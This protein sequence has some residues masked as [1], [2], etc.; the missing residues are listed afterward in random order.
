MTDENANTSD[1]T[2]DEKLDR[3]LAKLSQV[4]TRL[5]ALE[6]EAKDRARET[7]P[8]LDLLIAEMAATREDVKTA[9]ARLDTLVLDVFNV[10]AD[11]RRL[12]E[13]VDDMEQRPN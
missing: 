5:S 4:E 6:A 10:R 11:Q 9:L 3:V 13:R 2:I 7:R 12:T 1:L 8:K